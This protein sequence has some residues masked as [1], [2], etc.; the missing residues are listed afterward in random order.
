MKYFNFTFDSP[1][2]NLALDEVLLDLCERSS[3]NAEVLRFWEPRTYSVVL[4]YSKKFRDEVNVDQCEKDRLPIH[5]RISGGGTVLLGPGC[6]N[7]SL[8]LNITRHNLRSITLTNTWVMQKLQSALASLTRTK[9][10]IQGHTD[11]TCSG[12]KFSGNSQRRLH[13]SVLF[14]GTILHHFD[15][16]ECGKYLAHPKLQPPYRSN[17]N[18]SDF[19]R[20]LACTPEILQ[21][22][23]RTVFQAETPLN[24]VPDKLVHDLAKNRY[25]S[26]DWTCRF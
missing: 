7:Y 9:I 20:N 24:S 12:F 16:A 17:R 6:L 1:A 15:I 22:N 23:I 2:H 11:L 26:V 14:H 19:L 18:H 25:E 21:D 4:G 10:E 13:H 5:R 3:G 8:V